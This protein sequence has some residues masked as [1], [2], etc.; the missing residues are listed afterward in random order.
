M[1]IYEVSY[2]NQFDM[3]CGTLAVANTISCATIH[4]SSVL[5]DA[6]SYS[7]FAISAATVNT[8]AG[9]YGSF[10]TFAYSTAT[11]GEITG[12]STM[13]ISSGTADYMRIT[14]LDASVCGLSAI[15]ASKVL[16]QD[17]GAKVG[18]FSII[19]AST[20]AISVPTVSISTF[21]D[22]YAVNAYCDTI[23]A[24]VVAAADVSIGGLSVSSAL[25]AIQADISTLSGATGGTSYCQSFQSIKAYGTNGGNADGHVAAYSTLLLN[26][27]QPMSIVAGMTLSDSII[28]VP[29]GMYSVDS[30]TPV[31]GVGRARA[32]LFDVT[33]SSVL[34]YGDN[35]ITNTGSYGS[36]TTHINGILNVST[37]IDVCLQLQVETASALGDGSNALGVACSFNGS[38]P[39]VYSILKFT[40]YA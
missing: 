11:L 35:A 3:Y 10:S 12:V 40:K 28:G 24:G 21:T 15:T 39:E 36:G 25:D 6:A 5:Y 17:F 1:S 9:T 30:I 32:R 27:A 37:A 22:V 26:A 2:P 29:P 14:R 19:A 20:L 23:S 7:T 31:N 16:V 18:R 38:E 4:Y 33:A 13:A 8:L 34:L